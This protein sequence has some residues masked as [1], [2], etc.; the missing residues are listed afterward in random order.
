MI[1]IKSTIENVLVFRFVWQQTGHNKYISNPTILDCCPTMGPV[2]LA[3]ASNCFATF[4]KMQQTTICITV[5]HNIWPQYLLHGYKQTCS[6]CTW[7]LLE[8]NKLHVSTVNHIFY[9][10]EPGRSIKVMIGFMLCI[11]SVQENSIPANLPNR[12]LR[13]R[14]STS[15]NSFGSPQQK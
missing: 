7:S 11:P 8:R 2:H 10:W 12:A 5:V 1:C 3:A 6:L 9:F 4:F 15:K 13:T 14:D